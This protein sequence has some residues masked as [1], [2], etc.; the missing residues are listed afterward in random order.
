MRVREV[1]RKIGR[2]G[3]GTLME[4]RGKA[5][6]PREKSSRERMTGQDELQRQE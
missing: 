4:R 1:G 5:N 6:V 3:K 2:R